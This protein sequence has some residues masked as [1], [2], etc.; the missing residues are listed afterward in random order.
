MI[1]THVYVLK[2]VLNDI[3]KFNL[4]KKQR[5]LTTLLESIIL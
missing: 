5:A 4:D 3:L 1:S 2:F